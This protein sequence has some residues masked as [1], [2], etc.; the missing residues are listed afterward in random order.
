MTAN[1]IGAHQAN[2]RS[3]SDRWTRRQQLT[4]VFV[5]HLA[6][7][8]FVIAIILI[9]GKP[10]H[11][12]WLFVIAEALILIVCVW[13]IVKVEAIR[14]LFAELGIATRPQPAG[15]QDR[16][17]TL[18]RV[19]GYALL[20][21]FALQMGALVPLLKNTGGPINS[22]FAQMTVAV[23]IFTP[24]LANNPLTVASVGIIIGAYYVGLVAWMAQLN[25][26]WPNLTVNLG[27]L[28]VSVLLTFGDIRRR[29]TESGVS[30]DQARG[31]GVAPGDAVEGD[32]ATDD[33][34]PD[35][36]NADAGVDGQAL[37]NAMS[38]D[39]SSDDSSKSDIGEP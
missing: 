11:M 4:A 10:R 24:F 21:A 7:L 9:S 37:G 30:R 19:A 12:P 16:E 27:I 17:E 20:V 29:G 18:N 25:K 2:R 22:P 39:V 15:S 36:N 1:S 32:R 8:I 13:P 5:A 28:A 6:V 35:E 38:D 31:A 3:H 26:A 34:R 23:A 14:E 33:T